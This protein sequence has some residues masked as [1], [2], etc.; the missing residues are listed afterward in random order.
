MVIVVNNRNPN[1]GRRVRRGIERGLEDREITNRCIYVPEAL[2]QKWVDAE[3][4]AF[5]PT[6]ILT[7]RL[8][9]IVDTTKR[10]RYE[11][12]YDVALTATAFPDRRIWR[13]KTVANEGFDSEPQ[14]RSDKIAARIVQQ[15]AR[16]DL[17]KRER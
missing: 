4:A 7:V 15:L 2:E 3:I 1:E 16:D 13:G 10:E 8:L 12:H 5:K 11:T 17:L 6:G 14:D 9:G